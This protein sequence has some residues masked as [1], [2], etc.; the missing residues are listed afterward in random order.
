MKCWLLVL[1]FPFFSWSQNNCFTIE[2]ILVDACGFPE[3]PNEMVRIKVGENPLNTFD[4][5]ASWA[6]FNNPYQG[7]CQNTTTASNVAFMNSTIHSCGYFLEPSNGELPAFS[8]VLI[9][10]SEAFDPS[11][12]DYSG[13][14]DTIY[15]IFQCE[16]NTSGHFANW[17]NNCNHNNGERT[18]TISFGSNC[19]QTATYNRCFLTNQN[20][21]IGG[22]PAER[23]GAR[24]DFKPNGSVEYRNDGC[25]I[26]IGD[27]SVNANINA[28]QLPACKNDD[29]NVFGQV[30]GISTSVNWS[31]NFG[32]FDDINSIETIY[33]PSD[34]ADHYI[35]FSAEDG[36]GQ[37]VTDSILVSMETFPELFLSQEILSNDCKP[38]SIA[39]EA[40][41]NT[42]ISWSSGETST[43]I[44]PQSEGFYTVT[45]ENSCGIISDSIEIDFGPNL[46]L[47]MFFEEFYC[48]DAKGELQIDIMNGSGNYEIQFLIGNDSYSEAGES[49]NIDLPT[50]STGTQNVIIQSVVDLDNP[51]CVQ[52][53]EDT[54]YYEVLPPPS[55]NLAQ[56][57]FEFCQ[58]SDANIVITNSSNNDFFNA[59]LTYIDDG[60]SETLISQGS[61]FNFIVNTADVGTFNIYLDSISYLEPLYCSNSISQEIT[62]SIKPAPI[63]EILGDTSVCIEAEDVFY[64]VISS[65]TPPPYLISFSENGNNFNVESDTSVLKRSFNSFKS[66]K[67][68]IYLDA[69]ENLENGCKNELNDSIIIEVEDLPNIDFIVNP[70]EM[71][72][73]F[74]SPQFMNFSDTIHTFWWDYGESFEF[75]TTYNGSH[76][77]IDL[78]RG[79]FVV[80]LHALSPLGCYN[81][82]EKI[83]KY[84]PTNVVYVPNSFTPNGDKFNNNFMPILNGDFDIFDYELI[85]FNRWGELIFESK[86]AQIGW[87]GNYNGRKA[88][89]GT[90]IWQLKV[91]LIDYPI[92]LEKQG[93]LN[94]LR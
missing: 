79:T 14:K 27:F 10:T 45:A 36:C 11:A 25:T 37:I 30:V 49:F 47:E 40:L 68:I 56:S 43:N 28:N 22:T 13:L 16:G 12:H 19:S 66:G 39:L 17:I 6:N 41:S 48:L 5:Q 44:F 55:I 63:A 69:V 72:E 9:I 23:D 70:V 33:S 51:A 24:A 65:N 82:E 86:N 3:G 93:H 50:I 62:I 4:L 32:T 34:E 52:Y 59:E 91:G 90:Y 60:A 57:N 31:S 46:D 8:N 74:T 29:V 77:Y 75:D 81:S 64:Q 20:G 1:I 38:G 54:V 26:P 58:F 7:I 67:N 71:I 85:I 92:S 87:D 76:E 80:R 35:Y 73:D 88:P 94:L 18:T 2:S 15:V 89:E 78:E 83:I 21:G 53:I 42:A 61:Q 84:N